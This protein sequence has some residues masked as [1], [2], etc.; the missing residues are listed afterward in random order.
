MIKRSAALVVAATVA[1]AMLGACSGDD[2]TSLGDTGTLIVRLTDAPS[3]IDSIQRVDIFVVRVDGRFATAS[4]AE[5]SANVDNGTPGGW[6]TLATPNTSFNLSALR[7]G[8]TTTLG[9]G[10]VRAGT[11][12]AFRLVIDPAKSTVTLKSGR[13]LTRS[14]SPGILFPQTSRIAIRILPSKPVEIVG[15]RT[16]NLIV[17]FDVN[18]SFVQRGASVE[19]DGLLFR[20]LIT[21]TVVD[22]GVITATL[23]FVNLARTALTLWQGGEPLFDARF[24]QTDQSSRC[25]AIN[26]LELLNVTALGSPFPIARLAPVFVPGQT[27]LLV[28]FRDTSDRFRLVTLPTRFIA[29]SGRT[30]LRV[31]NATRLAG[32]LDVV[33][34]GVGAAFGP[35]TFRDVLGDSAS[36]FV[37]VPAGVS[38][39]RIARHGS[40][41]ALLDIPPQ[42]LFAGQRVTLVILPQARG[43][44][45]PRFFI[46][47]DC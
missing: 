7:N 24:I 17:D 35:A 33:V 3:L 12:R 46:V 8:T 41:E 29:G 13:V 44:S 2:T 11:Y 9:E 28:V 42:E 30:G 22:G 39:I 16:A 23:R 5:L 15:G 40:S 38:R 6:V 10:S 37:D 19:R 21:A 27:Y 43:L 31:F 4:D 47:P 20:P 1:A 26:T 14:S 34:A 32:G 45:T 36:A 18:T 25:L